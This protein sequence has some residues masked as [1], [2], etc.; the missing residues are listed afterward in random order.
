MKKLRGFTLIE[1]LIVVAIIAI[2]AAIAVPNF[3]EAQTRS[4]VSRAQSDMRSLA[5]GIESYFIDYNQY[6][7]ATAQ[8]DLTH[9][10]DQLQDVSGDASRFGSTFARKDLQSAANPGANSMTTPVSFITSIFPDPFA[11]PRGLSFRY[12]TDGRGWILGSYGPNGNANQ[13]GNLRW[14][15]I[16]MTNGYARITAAR[17]DGGIETVY[18][19]AVS[20]PSILLLTGASQG[21]AD[22]GPGGSFTYDPTNGTTS[23]GDLW[24]V[25]Q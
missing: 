14:D 23:P 5:T 16:Q 20:Q 1:L 3:L 11:S 10:W 6:P 7:A 8:A 9:D 2:L 19:S 25:R 22:G 12:W 13:G 24:R 18:N 21:G 4:R 17:I 15:Q